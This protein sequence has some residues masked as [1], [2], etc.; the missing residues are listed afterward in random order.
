MQHYNSQ[1]HPVCNAA[2]S[3]LRLRN[4]HDV[5]VL[6]EAVRQGRLPIIRRQPSQLERK[7]LHAG[8]VFVWLDG[9]GSLQR[10]KDGHH[11]NPTIIRGPF[12]TYDEISADS[13]VLLRQ[14][15]QQKAGGSR[16]KQPRRKRCPPLPGGLCKQTYSATCIHNGKKI[17]KWHMIAYIK[18]DNNSD[19]LI[20]PD[21]DPTL[22]TIVISQETTFKSLLRARKPRAS[23]SR[24][25]HT[26]LSKHPSNPA[27]R[28]EEKEVPLL[29][30]SVS[31]QSLQSTVPSPL[32]LP[33]M[34][35]GPGCPT[36]LASSEALSSRTVFHAPGQQ[37][38][39]NMLFGSTHDGHDYGGS[40][41][42][43]T[44]PEHGF[45]HSTAV[46]SVN[47]GGYPDPS[48]TSSEFRS[49][50]LTSSGRVSDLSVNVIDTKGCSSSWTC[51]LHDLASLD[52]PGGSRRQQNPSSPLVPASLPLFFPSSLVHDRLSAQ[53]PS[54]I[55]RH[56]VPSPVL[57]T[58]SHHHA[59]AQ[60]AN[61]SPLPY[62]DSNRAALIFEGLP[63]AKEYNNWTSIPTVLP[64]C[65]LLVDNLHD[66]FDKVAVSSG[67]PPA[68]FLSSSHCIGQLPSSELN[69]ARTSLTWPMHQPHA[70]VPISD[71]SQRWEQE[72]AYSATSFNHATGFSIGAKALNWSEYVGQQGA[73]HSTVGSGNVSE[74][75]GQ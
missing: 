26:S 40:S 19:E 16:V 57:H 39:M 68:A 33:V 41:N 62:Q 27:A 3:C 51:K 29:E 45:L 34:A 70:V 54:H 73:Q 53:L 14:K 4:A 11:W 64:T 10:W 17:Q 30:S 20:T 8:Q 66:P 71:L 31:E 59:H 65:G 46:L 52:W 35:S 25:R 36:A 9:E 38:P 72:H 24:A 58:K 28:D 18:Q 5:H 49:A 63:D 22:R 37:A 47:T 60:Q 67:L 74:W 43:S 2:H 56:P 48:L 44:S 15:A 13:E 1:I 6:F 21:E 32:L 50:F 61:L 7:S 23:P 75:I 42:G 12:L 55:R 69:P